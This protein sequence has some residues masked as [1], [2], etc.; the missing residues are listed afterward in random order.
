MP[1]AKLCDDVYVEV[2]QIDNIT[3]YWTKVYTNVR[4]KDKEYM[5]AE[6]TPHD[7][8]SFSLL[9]YSTHDALYKRKEDF[10]V[11]VRVESKIYSS[12]E[13]YDMLQQ[14]PKNITKFLKNREIGEK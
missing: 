6:M 12:K 10:S 5:F 7:D 8:N 2:S 13:H 11:Y 3:R 9:F 1:L 14:K 4:Y